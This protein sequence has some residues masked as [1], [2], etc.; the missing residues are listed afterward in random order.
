MTRWQN[1]PP[2]AAA[3]LNP[4]MVAAVLAG[5]AA[6]YQS[7]RERSMAWPL[8]FI[9]CPLVLHRSTREALPNSAA[10]HLAVWVSRH[11]VLHAGFAVRAQALV[12][13]VREGLRF[14]LRHGVLSIRAGVLHGSVGKARDP[15]LRQL[16]R[17]AQLV[18]RWLAK[19]DQPA[20]V[21]AI[22]GVEP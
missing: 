8:A 18:G 2:I 21:F 14:G 16:L 19:I 1:R 3:Y 6:G 20:T 22:L 12:P 17:S 7:V 13:A 5:S 10:T 4:A 11:A 15:E 9:V